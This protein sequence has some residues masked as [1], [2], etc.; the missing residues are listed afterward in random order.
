MKAKLENSDITVRKI[1]CARHIYRRFWFAYGLYGLIAILQ[2]ILGMW[3][4]FLNTTLALGWV[5]VALF[6]I[7]AYQ[8]EKFNRQLQERLNK[9]LWSQIRNT[10]GAREN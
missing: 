8:K 4:D 9:D 2:I 3:A 6:Y 5:H 7:D 1:V 10:F